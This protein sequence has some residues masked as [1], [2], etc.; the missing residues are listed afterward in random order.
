MNLPDLEPALL[1]ELAI[2]AAGFV[3]W[4]ALF[5]VALLVTRPADVQPAAPT[6]EF[7]GT[8]P[9]AVVSLLANRWEVTEDAAESTLLDLA[10]RRYLEFRQPGNDPMHT[11]VHV[12]DANPTGL[13]S[14]EQ[15]IFD[16]VKGLAVNGMV[17]MTALTFRNHA[18][19]AGFTKRLDAAV[20]A[21][22]RARGLSQR[23]F[24]AALVTGLGVA[25]GIPALSVA[26]AIALNLLRHG[27]LDDDAGA[28]IGV[29]IIVWGAVAT[30]AGRVKGER[31]TPEGQRVAARWLGL[32]A[33]LRG[34]ES[35]ADLPPSAVA[36]WDRYI[37]YGD[38]L[39]TT[40]VCSAVIDLGMGNRKRVW[41][42]FG[43]SWHRVKVR[44]PRYWRRYGQKAV[45]LFVKAF[46]AIGYSVLLYYGSDR[47]P[48]FP[49]QAA[50]ELNLAFTIM[51]YVPLAYGTYTLLGAIVDVA[52]PVQVTG[53]VL[54]VETWRSTSGGED[55]PPRP[56]LHHLAVDDGRTDRTVAWACPSEVASGVS[57]GD[58]VT[59]KVRRWT[60]RVVEL[61]VQEHGTA[62]ALAIADSTSSEDTGAILRGAIGTGG[63]ASALGL[64][65]ALR[66]PDIS[67]GQLVSVDEVG[68]AVGTH[69]T[70][71]GE[72]GATFGPM[73][74]V[75]YLSLSGKRMLLASVATGPMAT[76]AM[77]ARQH[78]Q[79]LPGIGDEA[80]AGDHW[81]LSRR[82]EHVVVLQ[83][84]GD[85]RRTDP[86]T[87]YWLLSTAVSRL[88]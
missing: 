88:P 43:G 33:Y 38:A 9:P 61:H 27:K 77:R 1:V 44:Y 75:W 15:A 78:G 3:V 35:F 82:G 19:A 32:R 67:V 87:V 2:A 24:S 62:R 16:R 12:R 65:G 46:L 14:Y 6:Q 63:V 72:N 37:A 54:W 17:P 60:R 64:A 84:H 40:R 25:A 68:R 79:A 51:F 20:I 76:L 71:Q 29:I 69:V 23:R 4:S 56:W 41:S 47:L 10:A 34:D 57:A 26:G 80:Y 55:K 45:R 81:A 30:I 11:T 66:A 73:N 13:T 8:E 83:L 31:D 39:G 22:A 85:G 42:S 21:D 36:V 49:E 86:R 74:M 5:G 52:T 28:I 53:E 58:I 18:Q 70:E 48:E 50:A 59:I 7:G